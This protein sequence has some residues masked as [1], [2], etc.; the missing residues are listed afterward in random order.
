LL[1]LVTAA[2]A[3]AERFEAAEA[4]ARALPVL[5]ESGARQ[6]PFAGFSIRQPGRAE[7]TVVEFYLMFREVSDRDGR[8]R[9]SYWV[10]RRVAGS[11]APRV[12]VAPE[13]VWASS[14]RCADL[15]VTVRSIGDAVQDQIELAVPGEGDPS[16][17]AEAAAHYGLWSDGGRFRGTRY[18]ASLQVT[19]IG[20]SP[21][22]VWADARSAALAPCWL[23]AAP[24]TVTLAAP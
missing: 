20:G 24:P 11:D 3:A 10:A 16:E 1:L 19:A 9:E 12:R 4:R 17:S 15:D 18:A 23:E 6:L 7:W 8:R 13:T 22:A 14:D 2:S 21:L 5:D